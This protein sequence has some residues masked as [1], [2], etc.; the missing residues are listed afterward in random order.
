MPLPDCVAGEG[1]FCKK[2]FLRWEGNG[3]IGCG[4]QLPLLTNLKTIFAPS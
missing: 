2:R 3:L 4:L 1:L